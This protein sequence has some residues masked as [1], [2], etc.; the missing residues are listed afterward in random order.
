MN[1]ENVF[2]YLFIRYRSL[3]NLYASSIAN[4]T[5]PIVFLLSF[6]TVYLFFSLSPSPLPLY[7]DA[8]K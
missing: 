4:Y 5:A 7:I 6:I 1:M 3:R 2:V 8:H